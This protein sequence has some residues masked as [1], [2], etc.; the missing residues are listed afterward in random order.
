MNSLKKALSTAVLLGL[1]SIAQAKTYTYEL[2]NL[3]SG[4]GPL[5]YPG[6]DLNLAKSAVFTVNRNADQ[7]P[8]IRSLEITFPNAG[9]LRTGAFKRLDNGHYRALV[10]GAWVFKEVIV[11]FEGNPDINTNVPAFISISVSETTSNLNPEALNQGSMLANVHGIVRDIT[12]MSTVDTAAIMLDGKR[13]SLNLKDRLG[14]S[15]TDG[16]QGFIL[17]ATWMGRGQ[18]LVYIPGP[19]GPNEW[20]RID[21]IGIVLE[22]PTTDPTVRIRF[23][24]NGNEQMSPPIPLRP[25]MQQNFP[26]L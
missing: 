14:I 8:E 5:N 1:A 22:G 12:S 15:A 26:T 20:D 13:L 18:K 17:D 3:N 25:L 24:D 23:K 11:Q 9:K 21:P 10:S 4:P 16:Q 2:A 7:L 19:L 6:L